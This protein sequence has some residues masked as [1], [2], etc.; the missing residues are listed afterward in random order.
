MSEFVHK[1]C[2]NSGYMYSIPIAQ[3]GGRGKL[4]RINRFTSF[5]KEN[6]GEFKLL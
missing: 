5:G 4:W 3:N 1:Y 2:T 6:V